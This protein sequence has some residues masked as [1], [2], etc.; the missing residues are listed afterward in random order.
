[1][2]FWSIV[3]LAVIAVCV[4]AWRMD[5]KHGIRSIDQEQPGGPNDARRMDAHGDGNGG[6]AGSM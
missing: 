4:I 3:I 5:R 2:V 6:M 1:M